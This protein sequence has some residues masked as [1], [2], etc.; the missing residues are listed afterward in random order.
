MRALAIVLLLSSSAYAD[1]SDQG[2]PAD[3]AQAPDPDAPTVGAALDKSEAYV[4]DRLALTVTAIAKGGIAVN[5]PQKLE[6]GPVELLERDDAEAQGRDLGDGRRSFRFILYVAD[7]DVGPAEIPSLTLTYLSPRGEVRSVTTAPVQLTIR[8][9]VDES[10]QAALPQP[11]RSGHSALIEDRRVLRA[12]YAAVGLVALGLIAFLVRRIWRKRGVDG[13]E[14]ITMIPSRPPGE[15]AIERL[16]AIRARGEFAREGYRPF[17]FETAE[18]V[19]AYLGARYGF[20]SLELT[21]TELLAELERVAPHLVQPGSE[22]VRFIEDTDLV[23]FANAGGSDASALALL[24]TAQ[25]IV[26]TTS[27]KLETAEEMLSGPVRPPMPTGD[28]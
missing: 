21:S 24:D 14:T 13:V 28:A 6:L 26:L 1:S 2:A 27:P 4:G 12:V 5:L 17:A 15:V 20:D 16:V 18:V 8:A 9:L 19:R 3:L 11:A 22:V 23:K 25:R 7:Y 10:Q